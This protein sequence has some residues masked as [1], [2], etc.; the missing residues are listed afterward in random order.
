MNAYLIL[1]N[2]K[3]IE[4]F[5]MPFIKLTGGMTNSLSDRLYSSVKQNSYLLIFSG[6]VSVMHE[7]NFRRPFTK[8]NEAFFVCMV[9]R[10]IPVTHQRNDFV[11]Q[12]ALSPFFVQLE[13]KGSLM[14]EN[15][16]NKCISLLI[17]PI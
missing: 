13:Q 7:K 11:K 1:I 2:D 15:C 17:D 12:K 8:N 3:N 9:G 10:L 16:Y 4:K 5:D 6:E 14:K